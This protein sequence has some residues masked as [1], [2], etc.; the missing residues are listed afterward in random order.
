M[1]GVER[2][3]TEKPEC[4]VDGNRNSRVRLKHQ[5]LDVVGYFVVLSYVTIEG[6]QENKDRFYT[7]YKW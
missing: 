2:K 6:L 4:G 7:G 3:E 1:A 5:L